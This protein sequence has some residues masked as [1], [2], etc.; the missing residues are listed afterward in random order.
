[1]QYLEELI[2][3]GDK[4]TSHLERA[5]IRME[6]AAVN[7]NLNRSGLA[8][9]ELKQAIEL[10]NQ[11]TH[12]TY[13]RSLHYE[14]I[15]RWM[16]GTLLIRCSDHRKEAI[17]NFEK[18]HYAFRVLSSLWSY[19]SI[20]HEPI[21]KEWLTDRMEEMLQGIENAI[22]ERPLSERR[23]TIPKYRETTSH[24]KLPVSILYSGRIKRISVLGYIP[25]GG[26]APLGIEPEP[27]E[28]IDLEPAMDVVIL[29][30]VPHQL[31]NLR[32]SFGATKLVSSFQYNI[33]KVTGD[34]M[35]Q[36]DIDPDDYV[37]LR[38][39]DT[40][41]NRDIVAVEIVGFDTRAILKMFIKQGDI[42]ELHPRSTNPKNIVRKFPKKTRDFYVR[43]VVLG[44]FKPA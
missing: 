30:G 33:L 4:C 31:F 40:A 21:S 7:F 19:G 35:N 11:D 17:S 20:N 29:D 27:L 44:V 10:L 6:C 8:I 15:A 24:T 5:L 23:K 43:G 28:T 13:F 38:E 3:T 1:L 32:G 18:S 2:I 14:A 42:I 9:V 39:Q 34:S 26:F 41:D 25:A 22:K 16:L 12:I 37:L 36:A